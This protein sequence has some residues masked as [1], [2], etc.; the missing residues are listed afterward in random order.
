LFR[1]QRERGMTL[2][3]ITHEPPLA[4]RCE[5]QLLM[6]DGRLSEAALAGARRQPLA[7]GGHA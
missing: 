2:L 1:V 7:A 3:L 6:A 4:A 5:R